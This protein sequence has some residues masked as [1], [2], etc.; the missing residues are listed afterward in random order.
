MS[1]PDMEKRNM[2]KAQDYF[3]HIE[4]PLHIDIENIKYIYEKVHTDHND[5]GIKY[6]I[7][8]FALKRNFMRSGCDAI[9]DGN[10]IAYRLNAQHHN[11]CSEILNTVCVNKTGGNDI[12]DRVIEAIE[13]FKFLVENRYPYH[14]DTTKNAVEHVQYTSNGQNTIVGRMHDLAI[15]AYIAKLRFHIKEVREFVAYYLRLFP[16][17]KSDYDSKLMIVASI[18]SAVINHDREDEREGSDL[19]SY[20]SGFLDI[21]KECDINLD[22]VYY[23]AIEVIFGNPSNSRKCNL[24]YTTFV[25]IGLHH[26]IKIDKPAIDAHKNTFFYLKPDDPIFKNNVVQFAKFYY[27]MTKKVKDVQ[28]KSEYDALMQDILREFDALFPGNFYNFI[29]PQDTRNK[30]RAI[31]ATEIKICITKNIKINNANIT[32]NVNNAGNIKSSPTSLPISTRDVDLMLAINNNTKP[33]LAMHGSFLASYLVAIRD[34]MTHCFCFRMVY[35]SSIDQTFALDQLLESSSAILKDA[36][37]GITSN[38]AQ[39]INELVKTLLVYNVMPVKITIPPAR[40][41][42]YHY[43]WRAISS[44]GV[45]NAIEIKKIEDKIIQK[46]VKIKIDSIVRQKLEQEGNSSKWNNLGEL[47]GRISEF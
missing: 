11:L 47:A 7:S 27:N 25:N 3:G 4:S 24:Y 6:F 45:H 17:L 37:A 42:E 30:L 1:M 21:I 33:S 14:Y 13:C 15:V 22:Y 41:T 8:L 20:I 31:L 29:I 35:N 43:L 36:G 2:A 16:E 12:D 32:N 5:I 19:L 40:F 28:L 34:A 44:K 23:D 46:S 26:G 38:D 9:N 10:V 39:N 18:F